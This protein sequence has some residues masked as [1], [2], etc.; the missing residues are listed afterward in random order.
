MSPAVPADAGQRPLLVKAIA[1]LMLALMAC[2]A[3][4]GEGWAQG[5]PGPM[6]RGHRDL[7]SFP[8]DCNK[9]HEAGY[10]VPDDKCLA[11]H[12]HQP[13]RRRIKAGQGFHATEAVKKKR[14]KTCH[15]EH[16]EEP[17]GS[18][19]GRRT[20]IDWRPF[21]GKRNFDH[22]L[23]GWPLEGTH[24]YTK[25]E[26]CHFQKYP[27]SRLPT[28]MG[29][30]QECTTCHFGTEQRPGPGGTN[31]H[32]FKDVAL[33]EC[34]LCHGFANFSVINLGATKFDHDRTDFPISGF[35]LRNKCVSCHAENIRDFKVDDAFEDCDGCH[36]DSHRSVIS[37]KRDCKSCHGMKT[38]FQKTSFDHGRETRWPLRGKHQ[39]NRCQDCHQ[40]DSEPVAPQMNCV[41]CHNDIHRGRFGAE[42]CEGCHQEQ[43]WPHM[44]YDHDRK[45]RFE[46]T[47]KHESTKCTTCH[48][49]GIERRFERFESTDCASCHRH[50]EAHCGQFGLENCERCH[51]RG[52]DRTSKFDHALTRFPLERAHSEA[53][54]D[55]CHLP[56]RLGS[57]RQ[58]R[59][60]VK[61][62]GLDPQCSTC[63]VDIHRGELGRDCAKCHTSGATFKTLV[64]DHN[65]DARFPLD[66]FHQIVNCDSCHP[67]RQYKLDDT[68][69]YSC[70]AKDDVH[71]GKLSDS[72]AECHETS[73]GAPKFDHNLHTRFQ[74]EGTHARIECERCHFLL[75]DGRSPF[76]RSERR[77]PRRRDAGPDTR[78]APRSDARLYSQDGVRA[79]R[80]RASDGARAAAQRLLTAIAPPGAP[81]DLQFRAAGLD[82]DSC[83]PDP[84]QVTDELD[85][86]SCHAF[87]TWDDPPRNDYHQLAGFSL[88]G[89]HTVVA[90]ELCH[91]GETNLRGRGERCG[92]CHVQD[93]V[94]SGSL[95]AD[96]GRCHEQ[97]VWFPSTFTHTDVGY[98]L[99]GIH[100]TLDCRSCHQAGNYFIS[101][102]CYACHLSDYRRSMLLPGG[103]HRADISLNRDAVA[104]GRFYIAGSGTLQALQQQQGLGPTSTDCGQCHTQFAWGLGAKIVP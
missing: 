58:C 61:Y 22:D 43:G 64:F 30:R 53:A 70:H 93:D 79:G 18:G 45:T 4:P 94:H 55:R 29:A 28:F 98:V 1:I 101:S 69:C 46:L 48:R 95:G 78:L 38:R 9:C 13:L 31:P 40:V 39:Q 102:D 74:Q 54:C 63:H 89:A 62:T 66:G 67:G 96:C 33:T 20:T 5:S 11:C 47:G 32:E 51:V 71:E 81:L 57:S 26:K 59:Q 68:T 56:A 50:Q 36:E 80:E 84:H 49:F 12:T 6:S 76:E 7:T 100:R 77:G 88:D 15:A 99:Q 21:G 44:T 41:T 90:C 82:C 103:W 14:C 60:T 92:S 35:H 75:A 23:A 17:P 16:I 34:Q 87:E 104:N 91:D 27:K 52:G 83:H 24:R 25:C 3:S 37:A 86:A 72:C 85:C 42:T 97:R 65:R 73:G 19:K 10:G 8:L 2:L